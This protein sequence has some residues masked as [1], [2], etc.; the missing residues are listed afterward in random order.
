MSSS[1]WQPFCLGLNVLTHIQ[2]EMHG[3][4]INTCYCCHGAKAR[5]SLSTVLTMKHTYHTYNEQQ[6]KLK[7][8]LE[9]RPYCDPFHPRPPPPPPLHLLCLQLCHFPV[10]LVHLLKVLKSF[11]TSICNDF[12]CFH[13]TLFKC[14]YPCISEGN[15]ESINV[16]QLNYHQVSHVSRTFVGN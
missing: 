15:K 10:G 13:R 1:K 12:L 4:I 3:S 11:M 8:V 6:I 16:A 2:Q 9:K 14:C 5:P 7:E